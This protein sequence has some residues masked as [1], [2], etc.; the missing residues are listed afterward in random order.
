MYRILTWL[1]I[2]AA[3][4]SGLPGSPVS[5]ININLT[6]TA[7]AQAGDGD[8]ILNEISPWPSDGQVWVELLNP[9]RSTVELD[10][11]TI[12]FR[13]GFEYTF[14]S[15]AGEIEPGR[16]HVLGISGD[17]PL[18]PDGDACTLSG[19]DGVTDTISWGNPT[20]AD[21][22]SVSSGD[23]LWP[24][25]PEY[26]DE[27]DIH[28]PDDIIFRIPDTWP[29]NAGNWIGS[30]HWAYRGSDAASRGEQ[31][32]YPP[33]V[34]YSP[35]D[36]AY[37]AS[38]FELYVVGIEWSGSTTFQVARDVNFQ[39][40]TIDATVEVHSYTITRLEAGTY[41]W[42]V[43]GEDG[44]WSPAM[45][46][47]REPYDIE[48]LI[49]VSGSSEIRLADGKE[50]KQPPG[51]ILG[52]DDDVT[53]SALLNNCP[54]IMQFKDTSMVCLMGCNMADSCDWD[55]NHGDPPLAGGTRSTCSHGNAYCARACIA[56][57]AGNSGLTLSQD[58]ITY[59]MF[60]E[61]WHFLSNPN[62]P[63]WIY[64]PI[65]DLAHGRGTGR[66]YSRAAID[67]LYNKPM[68]ST[69]QL[70]H[71]G[72]APTDIPGIMARIKRYID[73]GTPVMR[74][75][76]GHA[77]LISGYA[78]VEKIGNITV[79]YVRVEDPWI[80][81]AGR[82]FTLE[83]TIN[84]FDAFIF[85]PENTTPIRSN[86]SS[87]ALDSDGDGLNDFDETTR[88]NTD[89]QDVDTDGDGV[90]DKQDVLGYVFLRNGTWL[91]T[92]PDFDG[93][94]DAKELD[95]DNDNADDSGTID[96][97]ED[98]DHDGFMNFNGLETSNFDASDDGSVTNPECMQGYIRYYVTSDYCPDQWEE[99]ILDGGDS[100]FGE[101]YVHSFNWNIN[102]CFGVVM[103]GTE[104]GAGSGNTHGDGFARVELTTDESGNYI[105]DVDTNPDQ[106]DMEIEINALGS[107]THQ[108][109][110]LP[111]YLHQFAFTPER[112]GQPVTTPDG[113]LVLRGV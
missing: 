36:G 45:S 84:A 64:S 88:F 38:E 16:L 43:M 83:S 70:T 94:T 93:D 69:S 106:V 63:Q 103:L 99:V 52:W 105:L 1:I 78:I 23:P 29:P 15:G 14:P 19:P 3:L 101:D 37:V 6:D 8:L 89:P 5:I 95:P 82:W 96:G 110:T 77:T 9:T 46:F 68:G 109:Q 22:G 58:R 100:L 54:H 2:T 56:M 55:D 59:Y 42:R 92:H 33:P 57:I 66:S 30:E 75:G 60:E 34:R 27:E 17:N 98:A 87:I 90:N 12:R 40:V 79:H 41:Y 65:D 10:G 111:I 72:A 97:C 67:W 28:N 48:D 108:T 39:D 71:T 112:I 25:M 62:Q 20:P 31:N 85:P 24:F 35:P 18:N 107:T 102:F 11:W 73:A 91:L 53:S 21:P 32:P 74:C 81:A 51:L 7:Y 44:G 113:G 49:V 4:L 86:E 76:S 61:L 47:T 26:D 104:Y 80:S 13:S 50:G